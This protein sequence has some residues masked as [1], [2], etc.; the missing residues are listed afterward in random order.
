MIKKIFTNKVSL[1]LIIIALILIGTVVSPLQSLISFSATAI[2]VESE[3]YTAS[4]VV[5]YELAGPGNLLYGRPYYDLY[6]K[7]GTADNTATAEGQIKN[8]ATVI[9]DGITQSS[10]LFP[11][12]IYYDSNDVC[13]NTDY[14]DPQHYT[15]LTYSFSGAATVNEV[16]IYHSTNKELTTKVFQIYLS[17][18][19]DTLYTSDS[20]VTLYDNTSLES[21]QKF[22]FATPFQNK[23]FIGIRYIVP[24]ATNTDLAAVPR[25][26]ELA[27]FGTLTTPEPEVTEDNFA[28]NDTVAALTSDSNLLYDREFKIVRQNNNGSVSTNETSTTLYPNSDKKIFTD[29]KLNTSQQINGQIYFD[30][31]GNPYNTSPYIVTSRYTDVTYEFEDTASINEIWVYNHDDEKW[32]TYAYQLFL[33]YTEDTL[34]T[35]ES[36]VATYENVN[37]KNM[38]KFKFTNPI[39]DKLYFGIRFLVAA[40]LNTSGDVNSRFVRMT[41]LAVFGETKTELVRVTEDNYTQT[42]SDS[43][44]TVSKNLLYNREYNSVIQ[45]ENGK[46]SSANAEAKLK[47]DPKGY[48]D[49]DVSG[50][51][52]LDGQIYFNSDGTPKNTAP[53]NNPKYYTSVTY[54]LGGKSTVNEVWVYHANRTDLTTHVYQIYLADSRET[55]YNPE[56]N[57]YTY[58]NENNTTRQKF[59]FPKTF[60]GTYFGIKILVATSGDTTSLSINN[61]YARLTQLA[62]FG[63]VNEKT[64][65]DKSPLVFKEPDYIADL[66]KEYKRN[67]VK[68]STP[69]FYYNQGNGEKVADKANSIANLT[70]ENIN[71]QFFCG[72]PRFA[73]LVGDDTVNYYKDGTERYFKIS[74]NL[75]TSCDIRHILLV[76][77]TSERLRTLDY[78]VY[79]S[80][81]ADTLFDD[82][83]MVEHY[84]NTS[85]DLVN[86]IQFS[87]AKTAQ[88]VGFKIN[89][90]TSEEVVPHLK[91]G[92]LTDDVVYTRL[93]EIAVFGDYSDPNFEFP[94]SYAIDPY[95]TNEQFAALG[96]SIV[97]GKMASC[98]FTGTPLPLGFYS[99]KELQFTDGDITKHVDVNNV[100]T[101]TYKLN[102]DDGSQWIDIVYDWEEV[103]YDITGFL[104]AGCKKASDSSVQY[105]TGW[106]QVYIAEE[107]DDLFLQENMAFEYKWDGENYERGQLVNFD[108]PKRGAYFAIRI[109]NPVSGAKQSI[110]ARVAEIAVYGEKANIP[111]LPT[112]LA[113]NM[114]IE[115]YVQN[116]KG[117]LKEVSTKD[118]TVSEIKNLTDNDQNT[119]ASFKANGTVQLIYNLCNDAV[120]DA[121]RLTSNAKEYKV[122]ATSDLNKIWS[123]DSLV[124]TY[125]GSGTNGKTLA[126]GINVRY[127]RFE[128][129]NFGDELKIDE[130]ECIG[131]DNQ[132][133]KYKKL[134]R[135][136]KNFDKLVTLSSYDPKTKTQKYTSAQFNGAFKTLFDSGYKTPLGIWGGTNNGVYLDFI[137][138]LDDPDKKVNKVDDQTV[139]TTYPD[140]VRNIDKIAL[141]FPQALPGYSPTKFEIYTSEELGEFEDGEFDLEPAATYDGE[142]ILGTKTFSFAPRLARTVLV[143]FICG[144][145]E[146]DPYLNNQMTFAFTEFEVWGTKVVG[147]QKDGTDSSLIK[148]TDKKTGISV[149][150]QKYDIND[151]YTKAH[152][153]KVEEVKATTAQKKGLA[154]LGPLKIAKNKVY[155]VSLLD[156]NGNPITSVG[157]RDIKITFPYNANKY[158][159]PLLAQYVDGEVVT[160]D[161]DSDDPKYHYVTLSSLNNFYYMVATF[162][163]EDDP[164]FDNLDVEI[165]EDPI[166]ENYEDLDNLN[167]DFAGESGTESPATGEKLPILI[168][169][170]LLIALAVCNALIKKPIK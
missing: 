54:F 157:G 74:F 166:F 91:N 105:Y 51:V 62:V 68:G 152:Q 160:L 167:D 23:K 116:S 161:A 97:A 117:D 125:N 163:S 26:N 18:S 58:T 12:R 136:F 27:A 148:F 2:D 135:S 41:E 127:V 122:Y 87:E 137:L 110:G 153:I 114:P 73:E 84:K 131:G 147:M 48:T 64:E 96:N 34:Y 75:R 118:L 121:F 25:I 53:Y 66:Y 155:K 61:H 40:P 124:Y 29:G 141:S 99:K 31:S 123:E 115:A 30:A 17:D 50:N 45:F 6:S 151:I 36:L 21:M 98:S 89:Y 63:T 72:Q 76:N 145:T 60:E 22:K 70:N 142:P 130:V 32:R 71:D 100:T 11:G 1:S 4:T 150:I 107:I 81:S 52:Q 13:K 65:E 156:I 154:E 86:N 83:K 39:E 158:G 128:I 42:K 159:Y 9:T 95:M 165:P 102:T 69:K 108:S 47:S 134:S 139:V 109:L 101:A 46:T 85:L 19:I 112:N 169:A 94:P 162:T 79:L 55:L 138:N 8:Q 20:L 90:P 103:K 59:V 78:E 133:N 77:S 111:V 144:D 57:I 5:S 15:D 37:N 168:I 82:K 164:Y 67:L 33:S 126:T 132:V 28:T 35:A 80:D 7:D 143:R 93:N 44:L 129:S 49:G 146:Y 140:V 43:A 14:N 3:N 56:N 106:Y 113:K 16:W 104:Y 120:I 10:T 149:D 88:Y 119:S 170:I 24:T 92:T 38:Q